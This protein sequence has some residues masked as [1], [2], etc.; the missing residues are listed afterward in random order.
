MDTLIWVSLAN[1][2]F[3]PE[4]AENRKPINNNIKLKKKQTNKQ[5]YTLMWKSKKCLGLNSFIFIV[6]RFSLAST[7]LKSC[8]FY[9]N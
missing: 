7:Y 4:D 9:K 5:T 1:A 3:W 2:N 6:V 8:M